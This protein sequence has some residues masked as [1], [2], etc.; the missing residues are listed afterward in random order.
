MKFH[1]IRG[2]K[3]LRTIFRNRIRAVPVGG[4][5]AISPKFKKL[6]QLPQKVIQL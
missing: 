6:T 5:I 3:V 4:S 1:A 2:R